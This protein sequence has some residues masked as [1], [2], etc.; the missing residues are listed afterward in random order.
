MG[1]RLQYIYNKN[2]NSCFYILILILLFLLSENH[3]GQTLSAE[4]IYEKVKDAIVVIYAYDY[5]DELTKQGSGVVLTDKGYVITNYHVLSGCERLEIMHSDEII[6]YDDIIGIDV[7]KD[8]LILKIE[9]KKFPSIKVGN[10][11]AL[12]VGQRIYI[13]LVLHPPV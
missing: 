7:E 11:K 5:N 9:E 4:Q 8:I 3:S 12:K 13:P 2:Y 10:V 6:P 1:N